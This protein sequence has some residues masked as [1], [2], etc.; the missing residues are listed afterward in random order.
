MSEP[1]FFDCLTDA[2]IWS[3]FDSGVLQAHMIPPE[4]Y[5]RLERLA[6]AHGC[7]LFAWPL[8]MLPPRLEDIVPSLAPL[9]RESPHRSRD[10]SPQTPMGTEQV[11]SQIEA[12]CACVHAGMAAEGGRIHVVAVA[13][14][15]D[16]RTGP[17]LEPQACDL[18]A[19]SM[20]ELEAYLD[21]RLRLDDGD[22][23]GAVPS[24]TAAPL[25][26]HRDHAT[27]RLSGADVRPPH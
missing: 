2:Q 9:G 22:G 17:Y 1:L 14:T 6:P 24:Y 4:V 18:T 19:M 10:D 16:L 8:N 20:A 25:T 7:Y 5:E 13:P 12:F 15:L 27:P 21:A 26:H 11:R 23:T 3:L